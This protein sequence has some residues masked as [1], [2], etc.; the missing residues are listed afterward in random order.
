MLMTGAICFGALISPLAIMLAQGPS[1]TEPAAKAVQ[2]ERRHKQHPEIA[3]VVDLADS[4]PPEFS[5]RFLLQ[6]AISTQLHDRVWQQEL[7]E[8]AFERANLAR[9]PVRRR[10]FRDGDLFDVTRT[11]AEMISR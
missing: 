1:A 2:A 4:A 5:A 9:E 6:A 8:Q 10:G 3:K 11:R 7:L